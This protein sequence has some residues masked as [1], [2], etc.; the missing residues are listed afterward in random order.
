MPV[1]LEY[2]LQALDL[3]LGLGQVRLEALLELR[4]GC[5]VDHLGQCLG[6][7]TL[8]V[9]DVLERMDEEVVQALDVTRE[10]AHGEFLFG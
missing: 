3:V 2:L 8:G 5:L 1:H 9:V 4:V 6:D 7:L 10:Q